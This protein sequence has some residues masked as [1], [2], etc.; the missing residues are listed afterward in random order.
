MPFQ[1]TPYADVNAILHRLLVAVQAILGERLVA[2]YLHGSLAT[3]DFKPHTSD[4]DFLVV[5]AGELLAE[6]VSALAEMHARLAA[7]DPRWG[8]ELEG[9]YVP[10][11]ALRRYDP[12]DAMYPH[13]E[14]G[15]Q[16]RV[17]QHESDWVIQRYILRK[18]GVVL[19]GPAP[20]TLIDPISPP[21]L[22]QAML[23]L[24]HGWWAPMLG[25]PVR[26][27]RAGYR[28]YAILTMCRI[29]YTLEHGAIVSKP[30][31]ARWAQA[32]HG[33]RWGSVVASAAAW[34][35]GAPLAPLDEALAFIRYTRDHIRGVEGK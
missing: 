29:L 5:T 17:E 6:T 22:R 1:P 33:A 16:L 2:M 11:H 3:G 34:R 26:L 18:W 19:V 10:R 4:V 13:I 35:E 24:F 23:D 30:A 8:P 14:R 31:A 20:E 7:G 32:K 15:G 21:A 27:R 25:D 12:A 28:A 9:S